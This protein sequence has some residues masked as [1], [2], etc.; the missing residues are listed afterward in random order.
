MNRKKKRREKKMP[1]F[2]DFHRL[3][4]DDRIL[5]MGKM[6]ME[7]KKVACFLVDDEPGKPQRYI[8]KLLKHFP[9]INIIGQWEGPTP[10]CVTV[11]I[12]PPGVNQTQENN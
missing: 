11:K 2:V 1:L 12:G 3:T 4:E 7:Q 10:G 8:N 9:T 6:V 5:V